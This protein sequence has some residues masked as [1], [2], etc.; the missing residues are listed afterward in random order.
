MITPISGWFVIF[1]LGLAMV[2]LRTNFEFSVFARYEDRKSDAKSRKLG[3]WKDIVWGHSRSL[4]ITPFDRA[5]TTS[6]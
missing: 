1:R 2:N 4:E 5:H 3:G 6:Y